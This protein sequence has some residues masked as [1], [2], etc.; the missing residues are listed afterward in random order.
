MTSHR[1]IVQRWVDVQ[2][3]KETRL[4]RPRTS[5]IIATED[6]LYSYGRHFPLATTI[7][8][9][10][11]SGVETFLLNGDRYSVSTSQHQAIVRSCMPSHKHI[12][13]VPFSA[14]AAAGIDKTT[15]K[16]IDIQSDRQEKVVRRCDAPHKFNGGQVVPEDI[17]KFDSEVVSTDYVFS[18]CDCPGNV[19]HVAWQ[20]FLGASVFTATVHER[21]DGVEIVRSNVPFLSAFDQNEARPLY[22]L[23]EMP[24]S[25][26][27]KDYG[28]ATYGDAIEALKP[29]DVLAAD[30]NGIE[31]VRQGDIFAI[32]SDAT[33]LDL[34][35]LG[36]KIVKRS[37]N[38]DE[39]FL[40]NTNHTATEVM[41]VP[42]GSTYARGVLYHDPD[43]RER[44]HARRKMGDGKTWH[45]IVK[46][47]VPSRDKSFS[48][49]AWTLGGRVD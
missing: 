40:L 19:G 7:M 35:K 16:P 36:A 4:L 46:N 42:Y 9:D 20:H 25:F 33:T 41:K 2:L 6:T 23:C 28:D 26:A 13:I 37:K 8:F 14:L 31:Y 27:V 32:A 11:N 21:I 44:D 15:I 30:A 3:G 49:R 45:K 29:F 5:N 39:C 18:S 34:K 12:I 38:I 24:E 43:M 22:F 17:G 47:T 10:D 1:D 48:T